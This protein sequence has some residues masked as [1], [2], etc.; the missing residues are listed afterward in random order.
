[1]L[2]LNK[3]FILNE[4][5]LIKN[6]HR[7]VDMYEYLIRNY[8]DNLNFQIVAVFVSQK[9]K[10]YRFLLMLFKYSKI[11]KSSFCYLFRCEKKIISSI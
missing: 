4:I 11:C 9:D 3:I 8:L 10:K 2:Y 6:L 5:L 1:M 7:F